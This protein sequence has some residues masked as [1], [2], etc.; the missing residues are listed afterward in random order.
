LANHAISTCWFEP[1]PDVAQPVELSWRQ[2]R[3]ELAFDALH[4][5]EHR[6]QQLPS[7]R[8]EPHD[9]RTR[10][11]GRRLHF[12]V[13]AFFDLA[14]ELAGCLARDAG[15]FRQH[16]DAGALHIQVGEQ[17]R[18][19][20]GEVV[21]AAL[22]EPVDHAPRVHAQGPGERAIQR[23]VPIGA[24]RVGLAPAWAHPVIIRNLLDKL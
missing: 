23:L 24:K 4:Q 10:V 5:L 8:R 1:T 19:R 12:D 18:K 16:A 11:V 15:A 3:R 7:A 17:R 2:V 6:R 13:T 9:R 20:G 21:V 14:Q 22:V